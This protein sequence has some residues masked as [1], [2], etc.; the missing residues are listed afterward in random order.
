MINFAA[1][2]DEFIGLF[3]TSRV[4]FVSADSEVVDGD[5]F[6]FF[7]WFVVE[8]FADFEGVVLEELSDTRTREGS[9]AAARN[10]S[11][12]GLIRHTNIFGEER[13]E[14]FLFFFLIIII[15]YFF[16]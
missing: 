16:L 13:K 2:L 1:D 12:E 9:T 5:R 6:L 11:I 3:G 10:K 15:I 14:F 7:S 4:T 8:E